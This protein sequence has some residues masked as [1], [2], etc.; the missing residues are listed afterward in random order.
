M[1]TI[2]KI[3]SDTRECTSDSVRICNFD[4]TSKR[5]GNLE[6]KKEEVWALTLKQRPHL[7]KKRIEKKR[8][9][10]KNKE[11]LGVTIKYLYA[12]K[13]V[14]LPWRLWESSPINYLEQHEG[15]SMHTIQVPA[16]ASACLSV[17]H[18]QLARQSVCVGRGT[19]LIRN[20]YMLV[21]ESVH[22]LPI[23]NT[24]L[25]SLENISHLQS[26]CTV[27]VSKFSCKTAG[28]VGL[29]KISEAK[30]LCRQVIAQEYCNE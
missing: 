23:A 20:D 6:E 7:R 8:K 4:P 17:P 30:M 19:G 14:R 18:S 11:W 16:A 13:D 29:R 28:Q 12:V 15:V 27:Y 9:G 24:G 10:R 21:C 2:C 22:F 5:P 3:C 26:T 1:G 25:T